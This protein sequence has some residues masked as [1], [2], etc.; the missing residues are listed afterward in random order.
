MTTP[1]YYKFLPHRIDHAVSVYYDEYLCHL[2]LTIKMIVLV[3]NSNQVERQC[4]YNERHYHRRIQIDFV[5]NQQVITLNSH[6][7]ATFFMSR[8]CMVT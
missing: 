3:A 4:T 7:M 8:I 6:D 1:F 2:I 5:Q